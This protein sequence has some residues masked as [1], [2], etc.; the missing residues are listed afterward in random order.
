MRKE[1]INLNTPKSEAIKHFNLDD[2]KKT[3]LSIGGSLGAG[4][5]ND[6]IIKNLELISRNQ[7]IQLL[8]Q[9]GKFYYHNAKNELDKIKPINVKMMAFIKEMDKAY[10]AA[11]III[12]RAGAISV[13]ELCIA[14][15]PVV[16]VP[17]PNVAEDHQTKNAMALVDKNAAQIVRDNE[18]REKLFKNIFELLNDKEK[19]K[20]LSENITKLAVKNATELIVK[21]VKKQLKVN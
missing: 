11:D 13:S 9:S 16:F 3:I 19:I 5:I 18:A 4:T 20:E 17:S 1:I 8:W 10:Q 12:S 6:S 2:N 15:K 14:G 7:E 21:E